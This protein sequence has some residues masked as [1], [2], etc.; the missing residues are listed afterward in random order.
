MLEDLCLNDLCGSKMAQV[1]GL[2]RGVEYPTN[3]GT[4]LNNTIMSR[5]RELLETHVQVDANVKVVS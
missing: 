4:N 1:G 3:L 2:S 5:V